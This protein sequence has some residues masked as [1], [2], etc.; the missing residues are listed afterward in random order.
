MVLPIPATATRR[1]KSHV[2]TPGVIS[3]AQGLRSVSETHLPESRQDLSRSVARN[4]LVQVAGRGVNMALALLAVM[5]LSRHFGVDGM[6]DY[7]LI[8][9]ILT[10]LNLG[11]L[12]LFVIAVRELSTGKNDPKTVL[13]N[14][15]ILRVITAI[16]SIVAVGLITVALDYPPEVSAAIMIGSLSYIFIALGTGSLGAIFVSK[17]RMEYQVL[18]NAVQAVVFI[19]LV[20]SVIALDLGL[21]ALFAAYNVSVL[22]NSAVVIAASRQFIVPRLQ[23]DAVAL[24]RLAL[25]ALPLGINTVAWV[26]YTRIDMVLLSQMVDTEAVGL[27]GL[28]YRF[29]DMAWPIGFFFVGSVYPILSRYHEQAALSDF[30]WLQ[31][32]SVD[33]LTLMAMGP[34]TIVFVFAEPL[35]RI[36]GG[37]EFTAADGTLRILAIAI[38]PLWLGMLCSYTL[39][40]INRQFDLLWI[41]LAALSLNIAINLVLIPPLEH[42]GAAIATLATEV[43]ALALMVATLAR[44]AHSVPSFRTAIRMAIPLVPA[45]AA[46]VILAPD[47]IPL[48][49]AILIP[50]IAAAYSFSGALSLKDIRFLLHR[51]SQPPVDIQPASREVEYAQ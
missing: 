48:Q 50:A 16:V 18:A 47:S 36:V 26:L 7:F 15:L 20:G 42:T 9:S 41:G 37:S 39:A 51:P 32:R 5:G 49:V 28:A 21:V 3:G 46:A 8:S 14:V 6:G 34:I 11:D 23:V 40:S 45:S 43:V 10:L 27:Y 12:G 4:T 19:I 30:R 13:G 22:S 25:A 24:R 17:L 44:H 2:F 38:L 1:D 31:Q 33:V 29:P 35:L